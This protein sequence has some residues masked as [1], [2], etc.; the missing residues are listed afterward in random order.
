MKYFSCTKEQ[1][2]NSVYS[3]TEYNCAVSAY[4]LSYQKQE[5]S[6]ILFLIKKM[7]KKTFLQEIYKLDCEILYERS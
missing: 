1:L 2:W 7:F 4:Q 6:I 3:S 5:F